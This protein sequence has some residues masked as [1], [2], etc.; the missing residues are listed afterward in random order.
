M[1]CRLAVSLIVLT[2]V[3]G[4]ERAPTSPA[5]LE[6][7]SALAARAP[8]SNDLRCESLV[9]FGTFHDVVVPPGAFCVLGTSVVTGNVTVLE[10][11][12]LIAFSNTVHGDL[13]GE[14]AGQVDFRFGRI[15]GDVDIDGGIGKSPVGLDY[16]VFQVTMPTG[17]VRVRKVVSG[18]VHVAENTLG[19][20][21]ITV[22]GNTVDFLNVQ[23]NNL[24]TAGHLHVFNNT[25]EVSLVRNNVARRDIH[26]HGNEGPF[27]GT[28][29]TSIEGRVKGQCAAPAGTP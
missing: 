26:C 27:F 29:N 19:E 7:N 14:K 28:P 8:A 16:V 17:N 4:C 2:F 13:R 24:A 3:M 12:R 23:D 25:G 15:E 9:Q 6:P 21:N 20:G 11:A 5:G 10:G 22:D 1:R 18:N